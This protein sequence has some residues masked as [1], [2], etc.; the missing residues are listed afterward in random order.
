MTEIRQ[1]MV[2]RVTGGAVWVD[3]DGETV[4]CV[5]RGRM[6]RRERSPVVA[7]DRVRLAVPAAPGAAWPIESVEPRRNVLSRYVE[8]ERRARDV[9]ANVDRLFV[10]TSLR[11]PAV[12]AQFVDRVLAAAEYGDVPASVV[13]NKVDRLG[14]EDA[15]RVDAFVAACRGA[16]YEVLRTSAERGDGVD[17]LAGRVRGGL[18]AFVGASGVGKSSL[19]NRIDPSLDLP[20][21]EVATRTERGR[22][23]TTW[24]QLFRF[25]GGYLAD[26]PGVQTFG[27]P[28]EA[29]DLA[30]AFPEFAEATDACRYPG[31]THSHEPGCGVREAVEAGR[32]AASRHRSYR[33]ILEEVR[34]RTPRRRR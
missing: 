28:G 5:L 12:D 31:C 2:V 7:G 16:G 26:T 8:R 32:I 33:R 9:V 3:V 4:E 14:D 20:T 15:D 29:D 17:A 19:L 24:S 10:V 11:A 25:A 27:F 21:R 22:H 1:G 34:A 23:T 30:A 6:R 13:I 18:T